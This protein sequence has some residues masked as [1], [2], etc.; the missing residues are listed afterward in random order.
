MSC[1]I[2]QDFFQDYKYFN[3]CP[4]NGYEAIEKCCSVSQTNLKIYVLAMPP[5][6]QVCSLNIIRLQKTLNKDYKWIMYD[7]L[8]SFVIPHSTLH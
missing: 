5:K 6:F 7:S 3:E 4:I 1:A 2:F 8:A